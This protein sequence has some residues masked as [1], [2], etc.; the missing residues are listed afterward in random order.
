MEVKSFK[1]ANELS[2]YQHDREVKEALHVQSMTGAERFQWLADNW[3][4]LQDGAN[5]LFTDAPER[6]ATARCFASMEEKNRFD[7]ERE[8]QFA[9][10]HKL[11]TIHP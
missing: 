11:R 1:T 9:L 3:G 2:I 10:Q 4:R 5:T 8:V 7:R 6:Q